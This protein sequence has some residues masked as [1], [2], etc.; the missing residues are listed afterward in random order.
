MGVERSD[1]CRAGIFNKPSRC[2]M[3]RN[4]SAGEEGN[5]SQCSASGTRR[6]VWY[7][8]AALSACTSCCKAPRALGEGIVRI[9]RFSEREAQ[10]SI[11]GIFLNGFFTLC[12]VTRS[13]TGLGAHWLP[14]EPQG[15]PCL[16]S[17]S[18]GIAG[19]HLSPC[20]A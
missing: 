14:R 13:L 18:T 16:Y 8:R 12:L 19:V 3:R 6:G 10:R 7:W 17:F 2:G 5:S 9:P 4:N 15:S 20:P 11:F 1:A